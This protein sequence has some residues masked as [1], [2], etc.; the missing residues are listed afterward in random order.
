MRNENQ[1]ENHI[2]TVAWKENC[3]GNFLI[4][5]LPFEK[6]IKEKDSLK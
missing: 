4:C 1:V 3:A 6:F 2:T 5:N